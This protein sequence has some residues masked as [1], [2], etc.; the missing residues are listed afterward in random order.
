MKPTLDQ[1]AA[2]NEASDSRKPEAQGLL[3]A[4]IC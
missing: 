3:A 4:T 2:L 1:S